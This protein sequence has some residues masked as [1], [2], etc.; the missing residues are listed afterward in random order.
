MY[1]SV[2][3]FLA[4]PNPLA[5]RQIFS[6]NVLANGT[7]SRRS[8]SLPRELFA[9]SVKGP[10]AQFLIA[11]ANESFDGNGAAL[12]PVALPR[13]FMGVFQQKSRSRST[14]TFYYQCK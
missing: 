13:P 2:P 8:C 7:N 5:R 14:F 6:G 10:I 3:L 9:S 12:V 4:H 1:L 11:T